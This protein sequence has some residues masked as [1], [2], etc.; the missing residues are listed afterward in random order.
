M[1]QDVTLSLRTNSSWFK[2]NNQP[3]VRGYY[4]FTCTFE[5]NY[6]LGIHPL[7]LSINSLKAE[8]LS[9]I[10]SVANGRTL[11]GP[12]PIMETRLIKVFNK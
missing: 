9:F 4:C 5:I 7:S 2:V 1:E 6:S 12:W 10:S 11:C 8:M 3:N